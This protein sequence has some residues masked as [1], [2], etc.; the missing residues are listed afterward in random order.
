MIKS[1]PKTG[2]SAFLPGYTPLL[3]MVIK[4]TTISTRP[5]TES[6]FLSNF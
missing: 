4:P 2:I 3:L 1:A 5:I 6:M